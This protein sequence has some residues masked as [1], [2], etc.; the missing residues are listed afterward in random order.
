[1]HVLIDTA[2]ELS[3][4]VAHKL[5]FWSA[6]EKSTHQCFNKLEAPQRKP[7]SEHP[8]EPLEFRRQNWIWLMSTSGETTNAIF[9]PCNWSLRRFPSRGIQMTGF[10]TRILMLKGILLVRSFKWG[11]FH[12]ERCSIRRVFFRVCGLKGF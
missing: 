12:L 7:S 8:F 5:T 6:C 2:C 11:C 9:S 3:K 10:L 4:Q 1:M